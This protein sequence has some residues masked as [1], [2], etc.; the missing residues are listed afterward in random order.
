MK[1]IMV[2]IPESE[3]IGKV[4]DEALFRINR[5]NNIGYRFDYFITSG[6]YQDFDKPYIECGMI[7]DKEAYTYIRGDGLYLHI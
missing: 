3:L 4:R 5:Y 1:T 7:N 2:Y 6:K